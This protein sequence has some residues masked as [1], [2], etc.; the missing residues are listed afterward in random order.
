[1]IWSELLNFLFCF[2][3]NIDLK[4]LTHSV[5]CYFLYHPIMQNPR[6]FLWKESKSSVNVNFCDHSRWNEH[7]DAIHVP[8]LSVWPFAFQAYEFLVATY[9]VFLL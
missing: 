9:I 8:K 5:I 6:L 3:R 7:C 1:M 4:H 2:E